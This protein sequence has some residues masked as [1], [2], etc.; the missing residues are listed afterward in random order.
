MQRA[1][2]ETIA[3]VSLSSPDKVLFEGQGLTKAGLAAHYV[4]VAERMV[5][6]VR[7]RLASLVRCPDGPAKECFFQR[8]A[9]KGFPAAV[10]RKEITEKDGGRAEYLYVSD[11]S[12]IVA[13]VQMNTLEFHIWGSRIDALEKPD[14][15]VFD[16]DPAEGLDFAEVRQAAVDLRDRLGSL[17]LQSLPLVTGGKGV[18]VVAPLARRAEW[19]EV[20]AF[21]KAVA[22]LLSEEEP[23]R[24]LA[25]ASKEKRKGRIFID[26]LRN[27]RGASAIAPYSTRAK[28][29]AP[30]A[31]PVS[32]EELGRLDAA[33]TFHVGDME[34]RMNA[35]DPWADAAGWRQAIT[36]EMLERVGAA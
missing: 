7:N 26:W 35:P 9:G 31:T 17:G 3:G 34:A 22:G 25:Q 5:P 10:K 32:W 30:I 15:L 2:R 11:L 23:E 18:H 6:L 33:S 13:G 27:E 4:R 21:A 29:G 36:K 24:F 1:A 19:P 8:H 20:K 12:G 28:Q 14:R 16:L